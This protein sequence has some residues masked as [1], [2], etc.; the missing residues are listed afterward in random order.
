MGLISTLHESSIESY[1]S[2]KNGS[3]YKKLIYNEIYRPHAYMQYLFDIFL[4]TDYI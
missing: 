2:L 1:L 3:S 4:D